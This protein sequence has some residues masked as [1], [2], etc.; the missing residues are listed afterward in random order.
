MRDK[1]LKELLATKCWV[2][3]APLIRCSGKCRYADNKVTIDLRRKH[4]VAKVFLHELIHIRHQDWLESRVLWWEHWLWKT[5]SH[6]EVE[7]LYRKMYRDNA[8]GGFR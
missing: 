8:R 3:F 7:M 4:N 5:L 2:R 6:E 1:M